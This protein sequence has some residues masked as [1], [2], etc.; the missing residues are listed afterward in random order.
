MR[1]LP[2]ALVLIG[3]QSTKD[4]DGIE[5]TGYLDS[6]RVTVSTASDPGATGVTVLVAGA[7]GAASDMDVVEIVNLDTGGSVDAD[8]AEDGSFAA[9]TSAAVG[10]TLELGGSGAD[11]IEVAFE[12]P[13]P[14]PDY[15]SL[16]PH[17][18]DADGLVLVT[19]ELTAPHP[20]VD[21]LLSN[22]LRSLSAWTT[23]DQAIY[24]GSIE[25]QVGDLIWV[26]ALP[27]DHAPTLA[28]EIPVPAN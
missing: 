13:T 21:V 16:N 27:A 18:P 10:E 1:L 9:P 17:P 24:T 19:L 5:I 15:L 23:A 11:P 3:C 7:P 14:F 6:S 25:G 26:Q 12:Q 20:T 8:V 28:I 22:P 4:K 2:L